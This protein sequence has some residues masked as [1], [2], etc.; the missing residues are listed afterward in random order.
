MARL[1]LKPGITYGDV[2]EVVTRMA[3]ES[4][5]G[6]ITLASPLLSDFT[7]LLDE[8]IANVAFGQAEPDASTKAD[9]NSVYVNFHFDRTIQLGEN[10]VRV[11]NVV[12][13]DFDGKSADAS[14]QGG[15]TGGDGS[16]PDLGGVA[17]EAFG[18]IVICGCVG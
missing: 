12:I 13:P 7:N 10:Q 2:G 6:Q 5:T 1:K 3:S 11:V 16:P 9:A 14:Q 17:K 4:Q 15:G 18:F 8:T